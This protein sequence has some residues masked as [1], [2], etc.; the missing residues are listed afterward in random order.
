VED[1]FEQ[2]MEMLNPVYQFECQL[3]QRFLAWMALVVIRY[4]M[5]LNVLCS[6]P[7]DIRTDVAVTTVRKAA[8]GAVYRIRIQRVSTFNSWLHTVL[9]VFHQLIYHEHV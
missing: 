4:S 5:R 3:H 1:L 9:G 2:L 7:D 6:L 8:E